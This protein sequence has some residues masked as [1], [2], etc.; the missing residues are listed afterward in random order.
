MTGWT[1]YT[2][3]AMASL[4]EALAETVFPAVCLLCRRGLPWRSG[5]GG[6]CALCWEAA[7]PHPTALCPRCGAPEVAGSEACLS[8]RE[9]PPVWDAA[10]SYG[11][12]QGTLRDL[13]LLLKYERRDELAEPLARLL[14]STLVGTGWPRPDAIVPVPLAWTRHL[15]RGFNQAA[16]LAGSLGDQLDARVRPLLKRRPGAP[17]VGRTS[18]QRRQLSATSFRPRRPIS[19][20]LLLVDDVLTTGAT[21]AA[22]SRAL[23]RAGADSVRVLTLART[24]SPGRIP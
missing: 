11:P 22:C 21:A 4:A 19:G 3:A 7:Y 13:V 14:L 5:R 23:R 16:L 6:V 17:Q 15:R 18:R 2:R 24:P 10:A 12:Y 9:T 1:C 20:S 8:C